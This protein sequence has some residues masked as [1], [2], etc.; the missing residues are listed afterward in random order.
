M[1]IE[2]LHFLVAEDH[3]F[4]RKTLVR[5]LSGL[6]AKSISEAANGKAALDIFTDLV[7]PV[8]IIVSDLDMPGMDGMEFMRHLG[9]LG[10]PVSVI[11]SSAL[12]PSLISSVETMTK[13]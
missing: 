8:D 13:E 11:L 5:M 7:H 9:E 6:G 10:V 1:G 12:D 3:D 4:Q 2:D